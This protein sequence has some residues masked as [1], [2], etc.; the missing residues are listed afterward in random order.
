[1]KMGIGVFSG[2]CLP[3]EGKSHTQILADSI[4]QIVY[5][6]SLGLDSC[7]I[8]EHHFL[9]N[10]YIGS[11]LPY[12]AAVAQATSTMRV[13]VGVALAPLY[14]PVRMAE[15]AAFVDVLSG[16][17]HD[18]GIAIGYRDTEY[19]GFGTRRTDRVGR[20][21]EFCTILRQAWS[22]N[23]VNAIGHHFQR[24]GFEV[25]PKPVQPGGVPI[26]MGGHAPKALDR[27][28][29]LADSFIMDAGTDSSVFGA[30]GKNR[31][32]YGRVEGTLALYKEC[33]ARHDRP[34]HDVP[35][36]LNMGGFL[37]PDGADAAWAV[38][39]EAYMYTR[40]VY[41]DWYDV[42]KETYERWYPALMSPDEHNQRRTEVFL[43]SPDDLVPK[44]NQLRD[45]A[46]PNL[47]IMFRTKY[48]GITDEDTRRSIEMLAEC[49]RLL[50][51]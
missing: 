7:W 49:N 51:S 24:S 19:Q 14:D 5:A 40:R 11:V 22:N 45:I 8:T 15:D 6:E 1:M 44:F 10:G 4:S 23:P 34:T 50:N 38:Q 16:G 37:H 28:A 17:R 41:G 29:R 30:E 31:D 47:H 35:F 2:E 9:S 13:G 3:S 27:A 25:Y 42:P 20:M 33:L 32:I 21:E 18:L 39:Q 26:L 48:P 12:A 46:G 36:Y 43:G